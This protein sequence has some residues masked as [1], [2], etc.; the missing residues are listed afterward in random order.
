[1]TRN[2]KLDTPSV[3][4]ILVLTKP[5]LFVMC[6]LDIQALHSGLILQCLST[7]SLNATPFQPIPI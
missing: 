6:S 4:L 2:E 1:M 3:V 5:I 7:T